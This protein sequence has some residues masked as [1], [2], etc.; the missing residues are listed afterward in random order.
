MASCWAT[1]F[2]DLAWPILVSTTLPPQPRHRS[3]SKQAR[4]NTWESC[5][6]GGT[7]DDCFGAGWKSLLEELHYYSWIF[8][9]KMSS[10]R[11][12]I[13]H[14]C[15]SITWSRVVYNQN[16]TWILQWDYIV[17]LCSVGAILFP[18]FLRM[19]LNHWLVWQSNAVTMQQIA[20]GN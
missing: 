8:Y 13:Q 19:N 15:S 12:W 10:M 14:L 7:G 9:Y 11:A 6:D 5:H 2:G 4:A 3:S 20:M 18:K 17:V 16:L 1:D